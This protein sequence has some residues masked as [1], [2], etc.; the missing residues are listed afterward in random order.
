MRDYRSQRIP[1]SVQESGEL[2]ET[3]VV[4]S[5]DLP[6]KIVSE[7]REAPTVNLE[8]GDLRG[9]LA[10]G[11]IPKSLDLLFCQDRRCAL[12]STSPPRNP[13]GLPA[14]GQK[15]HTVMLASPLP[16]RSKIS[17]N[18]VPTSLVR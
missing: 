4:H 6:W 12:K 10:G 15:H 2:T 7:Q 9:F 14:S 17:I 8:E 13:V 5:H 1:E 18:G 11:S 16:G 3:G